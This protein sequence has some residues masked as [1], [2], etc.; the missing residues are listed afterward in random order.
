MTRYAADSPPLCGG[1]VRDSA[2]VTPHS[3]KLVTSLEQR[4]AA[5]DAHADGGQDGVGHA[6]HVVAEAK[7]A[8]G[9]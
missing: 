8:L 4:L 6:H 7:A 5:H 1:Q 3:G 9:K 2:A